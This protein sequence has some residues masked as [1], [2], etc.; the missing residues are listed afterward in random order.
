LP[1]AA[2]ATAL[3]RS[4]QLVARWEARRR[5]AV[6][7]VEAALGDGALA[8]ASEPSGET[9]A[10]ARL[11][12]KLAGTAAMF[13]EPALGEAAG[14]LERALVAPQDGPTRV[15]LAQALLHAATAPAGTQD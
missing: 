11:L 4:P 9:E 14:A 2:R 3:A 7:A 8:A 5:E 1:A 15:R 12:H 13:G 6:E 10:L